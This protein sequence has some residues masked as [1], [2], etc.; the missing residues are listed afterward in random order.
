VDYRPFDLEG[1]HALDIASDQSPPAPTVVN[2][3]RNDLDLDRP[4]DPK[5]SRSA[6]LVLAGLWLA[7]GTGIAVLWL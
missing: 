1:N 5:A 7:L 3:E 6:I 4:F 2:I